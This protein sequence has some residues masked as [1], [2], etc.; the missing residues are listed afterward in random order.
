MVLSS[1]TVSLVPEA[2]AGPFVFHGD[3]PRACRQAA[4]LGFDGIE[5][6]APSGQHADR[7]ELAALLARHSLRLAAVG[8]G[9]GMLLH[10]HSLCD[11]RTNARQQACEFV[12]GI[13]D[14]GARFGAPAIIGSMQG[15]AGTGQTREAALARLAESLDHLAGC[16]GRAGQTLLLEP[17]NRY[18][19]DLVRTLA[20]GTAL[21]REVGAGNLR[22][23]ADLFHMNIEEADPRGSLQ[24][25]A[26]QIGH[27]H[28]VDSNR[29]AAGFGH[30]RY[31]PL[32]QALAG[33][34]FLGFASAEAFPLPSP[35]AAA[36]MTIR[37]FRKHFR[38]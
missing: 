3:L 24:R 22:L 5:I 10:G 8:T 26:G 18:E 38:R 28:F 19:T 12:E 9:A 35:E 7:A 32:A 29:R 16:A 31:G 6:F 20:D 17:L 11:P 13:I 2:S 14:F 4:A 36:E 33:A 37:S 21:L 25:A 30:M 34:G 27:V 1:V 15:Q 23:L